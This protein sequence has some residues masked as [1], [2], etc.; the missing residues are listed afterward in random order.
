[1][2]ETTPTTTPAPT[3]ATRVFA[4]DVVFSVL[5]ETLLCHSF[6]EVHELIEWQ[7]GYPVM[8]HQLASS[9]RFVETAKTLIYVQYPSLLKL[10]RPSG[11]TNAETA[12]EWVDRQ[13]RD[14]MLPAAYTL[15][16][17]SWGFDGG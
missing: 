5:T 7:L 2:P 15:N 3:L 9:E 14:L 17:V 6:S 8:T 13:I 1:M 16:R 4:P 10:P 12:G 11:V